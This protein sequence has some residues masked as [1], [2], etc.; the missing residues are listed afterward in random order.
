MFI[1]INNLQLTHECK[2]RSTKIINKL[3]ETKYEKLRY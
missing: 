3:E 1:E 2:L